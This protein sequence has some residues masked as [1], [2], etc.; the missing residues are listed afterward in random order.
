MVTSKMRT[1]TL[2]HP[3]LICLS[4]V[5]AYTYLLWQIVTQSGTSAP[6]WLLLVFGVVWGIGVLIYVPRLLWPAAREAV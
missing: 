1:P 6:E 2:L 4:S 3:L 5:A